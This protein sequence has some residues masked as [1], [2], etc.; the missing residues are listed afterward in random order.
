MAKRTQP[1]KI[2]DTT[3]LM[4]F[5]LGFLERLNEKYRL[6][7][8]NG[9]SMDFGI[10]QAMIELSNN[11]PLTIAYIIQFAT[12][13]NHNKPSREDIE[14]YIDEQTEDDKSEEKLFSDFLEYLKKA[15]G[16]ARIFK[17]AKEA[18]AKLK[19]EETQEEK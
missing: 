18:Q 17:K 15:P 11:N 5:G 6:E 8:D 3:Y 14:D 7:M 13:D 4:T 12:A 9:M 10:H 1:I 16:A 19:K 2:N